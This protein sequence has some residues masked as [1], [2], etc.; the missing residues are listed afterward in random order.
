MF[1]AARARRRLAASREGRALLLVLSWLYGGAVILRR[2]LYAAGLLP[3]RK[4]HARTICIGNLTT[5][6]TGKT[7][8]VLLAAQTFLRKEKSVAILTRG[9]R[10]PKAAA[11]VSVLLNSQENPDWRE[12]GDEA[13]MM[14]HA[15]RGAE[16]PILVSG[17]R[18]RAAEMAVT[19]YNPQVLLLDDGFQHFRLRRDL[20]VVL[21]NARDP[22]GGGQLLP[23]GNLREPLG[24]LRR[25]GMVLLTHTD[26]VPAEQLSAIRKRVAELHPNVT[27]VESVHRPAFFFDLIEEKRLPLT[28]LEERQVAA[29]CAIGDPDPFF[30]QLKALGAKPTQ[31]WRF[32]DHHP[33]TL[34]E[35]RSI[36]RPRHGL[37]IVTTFKDFSR[38]P[39]GW[40][41]ALSAEV[42]ALSIR[43][44]IVKGKTA[45]EADLIRSRSS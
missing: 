40:R 20:D 32:P 10:R 41:K 14:H 25:A 19:Y 7:S 2:A 3:S 27:V 38:F 8:A 11:K 35:L 36:D 29:F 16:V 12:Y 5:G 45:W 13:W 22:W 31:Q 37:P 4:P 44:E 9:Y 15:L 21:I 17:D 28:H 18:L 33:Y 1:D 24:G 39:E 42:L 6:G 34:E 43:L 23:R 26:Q 30:E